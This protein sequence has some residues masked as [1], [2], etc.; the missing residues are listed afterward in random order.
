MTH[1]QHVLNS[2][3]LGEKVRRRTPWQYSI[4]TLCVC[5]W[6]AKRKQLWLR[7]SGHLSG[8][9]ITAGEVHRNGQRTTAQAK[10]M[11]KEVLAEWPSGGKKEK[12]EHRIWQGIIHVEHKAYGEGI[13]GRRTQ[14]PHFSAKRA[15]TNENG[16]TG[17]A[18]PR[19]AARGKS[20]KLDT[21]ASTHDCRHVGGISASNPHSVK[22]H[23]RWSAFETSGR[24][25][26][27][28]DDR[29]D[30]MKRRYWLPTDT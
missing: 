28:K 6:K 27:V 26:G 23:W 3:E 17:R 9:C 16:E 4:L 18:G 20:H 25:G 19:G 30:K 2:G 29:R 14:Q 13:V 15:G 1:F 21:D 24:I 10:A 5:L 12:D 7:A 8:E 22:V 11:M